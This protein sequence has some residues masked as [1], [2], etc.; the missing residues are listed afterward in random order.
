MAQNR[1]ATGPTGAAEAAAA[2]RQAQAM[3][4][5]RPIR[6]ADEDAGPPAAR[7]GSRKSTV[8][9]LP[10]TPSA[11]STPNQRPAGGRRAAARLEEGAISGQTERRPQR[12]QHDVVVELR[13][14]E[15]EVDHAFLR[16]H[17]QQRA[18]R[19]KHRAGPAAISRTAT[20][21]RPA[22]PQ[23]ERGRPAAE[24][25]GNGFDD[26]R[27]QR[28]VLEIDNL[29]LAAPGELF[30]HVERQVV[31]QQR[32]QRPP[33]HDVE[34]KEP[35]DDP[36]GRA[37]QPS[38]LD[39]PGGDCGASRS[40][41]YRFPAP[42]DRPGVTR[43]ARV[44]TEFRRPGRRPSAHPTTGRRRRAAAAAG[45]RCAGARSRIAAALARRPRR[46]R[47]LS[48]M[49]SSPA[50]AAAAP[51]R[52]CSVSWPDWSVHFRVCIAPST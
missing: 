38:Q 28:R 20:A 3:V 43:T 16:Q 44:R 41:P 13:R 34:G 7:T 21:P 27:R 17:R 19:P 14:E 26:P 48:S 42:G 6:G 36:R 15:R 39:E 49:V 32:R 5:D 12:Q 45:A 51:P 8:V 18:P 37:A 40:G 35:A 29:P 52:W 50:E 47:A 24:D 23:V 9:Y 46:R 25:D 10:N 31:L 2:R 33:D 22:G 1:C 11:A 30:D 4:R